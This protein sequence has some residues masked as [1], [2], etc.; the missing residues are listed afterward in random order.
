MNTLLVILATLQLLVPQ[1]SEWLHVGQSIDSTGVGYNP[2]M[3]A[4]YAFAIWG[5]IFLLALGYAVGQR[6]PNALA[7][8]LKAPFTGVLITSITWMTLAQ[9]LGNGWW[10]VLLIWAMWA[11][12]VLGLRRITAYPKP[13]SRL[14]RWVSLPMFSMYTAWLSVAV[15]LNTSD[16]LRM[17]NIVP[18]GLDATTYASLFLCFVGAF[19][20]ALL[21]YFNGNVWLG[22][23]LIWAFDAILV[24]NLF[25]VFNLPVAILATALTAVIAVAIPLIQQQHAKHHLAPA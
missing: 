3:P 6:R 14:H 1:L 4:G 24:N 2:E 16:Y 21:R 9:L 25:T 11:F 15:W 23:T 8:A 10:L 17:V 13:L 5:V 12:S 20:L 18:F 22:V 19:G 7:Q